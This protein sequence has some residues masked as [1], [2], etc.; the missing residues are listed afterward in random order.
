MKGVMSLIGDLSRRPGPLPANIAGVYQKSRAAFPLG[1]G[2]SSS[3]VANGVAL[4]G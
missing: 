4:I 1:F 2:H 3:Y